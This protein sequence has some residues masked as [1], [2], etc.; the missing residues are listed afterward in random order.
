[1]KNIKIIFAYDGSDFFG[2]QAQTDK[3]TVQGSIEYAIKKVT[4]KDVR[5][6]SAGRTDKGVH[7]E[8]QVANFFTD[9]NIPAKAY[10]YNL[11]KYL[12]D[13]IH[14]KESIEVDQDFHARFSAKKKTYKFLAYNK[15]YM[16]PNLRSIYTHVVYDLDIEK[17]RQASKYLLGGHDF[18]AFSKYENK[19]VNTNRSIDEI[20]IDREGDLVVFTFKAESFLYNQVRIMVG[21][22]VDV[23]RG[24][25][26]P[27]YIKEIIDS[28]DR[29]KAGMTLS[30]SGLYLMEIS[31]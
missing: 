4:G 11:R 1:M 8:N 3:K 30:P 17:M 20:V 23:G 10:K 9:S 15:K 22:L 7:A 29:L 26:P 31:Y 6:M 25:R 19:P 24:H 2:Y 5:L 13:S 21:S 14:I 16:H 28:K 18:K 27:D 12:P